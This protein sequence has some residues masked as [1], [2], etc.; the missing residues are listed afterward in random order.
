MCQNHCGDGGLL[1]EMVQAAASAGADY[2]KIQALYSSDLTRRDRFES[3]LTD[4]AG[5]ILAIRRPFAA[6][7]DRL[8]G[9][10]LT[11]AD[12]AAFVD[13]CLNS[14][15]QPLITVFTRGA[16]TRLARLGFPAVKIAS[17]D[18]ASLPLLRDVS[19][20]WDKVF[21]STGSMFLTEVENAL[22]AL[23]GRDVTLLHC[24]TVYPTPFESARLSRMA[25]LADLGVPVG[26][27][28]HTAVAEDGVWASKAAI[29]LGAAAIERHF[30]ILPAARTKDGPV[31]IGP[32][33]LAD[34]RRFGALPEAEQRR[35]LDDQRPDW[36]TAVG[37][38]DLDPSGAELLNRD[39]YA[40]RVASWV[41]GRAVF[42][43][44]DV[45]LEVV[46]RLPDLSLG[47]VPAGS[48]A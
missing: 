29:H 10:D 11:P 13:E 25:R 26:F 45:D 20:R 17:Y 35:V 15:V 33:Q 36:P 37:G 31:S 23:S 30:T 38:D 41:A 44:E 42:N 39:Y 40:G 4:A 9:L 32:D 12:E 18:C 1:K 2:A 27:S 22:A 43:W 19:E 24:V 16:V 8:S 5:N 3:G 34:L 7:R 28:D 6:E 48:V 21:V 14:G 46:A 47:A